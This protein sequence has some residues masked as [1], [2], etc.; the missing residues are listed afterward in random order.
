[1]DDKARKSRER[2]AAREARA[3]ARG[4]ARIFG[5]IFVAAL[6]WAVI[7]GGIWLLAR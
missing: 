7:I 3:D 5:W 2:V 6:L 4:S 1:M